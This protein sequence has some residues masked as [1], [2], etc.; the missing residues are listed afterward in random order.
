MENYEINKNIESFTKRLNDLKEAID[1]SGLIK[2]IE[3]DEKISN[4]NCFSFKNSYS[5]GKFN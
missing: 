3:E 2:Q 1:L 5:A 4:C